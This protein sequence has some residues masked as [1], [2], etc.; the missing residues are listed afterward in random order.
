MPRIDYHL[1]RAYVSPAT[2]GLLQ[3]HIPTIQQGVPLKPKLANGKPLKL[4]KHQRKVLK[5]LYQPVVPT[6]GVRGRIL[7][8][9]MGAGKT[10]ISLVYALS[11]IRRGPNNLPTLIVCS[12]TLLDMWKTEGFDKFLMPDS[13]RVLYLHSAF[14]PKA[15]MDALTRQELCTY[16]VVV[17]TYDVLVCAD[18]DTT[19]SSDV[20][21]MGR[22]GVWGE[23]PDRVRY[24]KKRTRAQAD[25]AT[26]RGPGALF[27]TPWPLVV[28]DEPQRFANFKTKTF[29]AMMSVFGEEY[30]L[31][32]GTP[33]RN[34]ITDIW[35]LYR[36]M[37]YDTIKIPTKTRARRG[38]TLDLM[39]ARDVHGRCLR[40]LLIRVTLADL[41]PLPPLTHRVWETT[42]T[43]AA[44]DV[45]T[46]FT[47]RALELLEQSFQRKLRCP[48]VKT[49][50]GVALAAFTKL[51][52]I[53][54]A[55]HLVLPESK[56]KPQQKGAATSSLDPEN[57]LDAST[58]EWCQDRN[59]P[60][61]FGAA[62]VVQLLDLLSIIPATEKVLV[63]CCF[64]STIDLMRAALEAEGIVSSMLDGDVPAHKRR[65]VTTQFA[66]GDTRVLF[67]TYPVAAEGLNLVCA[68][69]VVLAEAWW[70]NAVMKQAVYRAWRYGQAKPVEVYQLATKGTIEPLILKLAGYKKCIGDAVL[71]DIT[72]DELKAI[73]RTKLNFDTI[74]NIVRDAAAQANS[75]GSGGGGGGGGGPA[76]RRASTSESQYAKRATQ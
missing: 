25:D 16:D 62:K 37:G 48:W 2:L 70:N 11:T 28:V 23:S 39:D 72:A 42:M 30:L 55:P 5:Q 34:H 52:Q 15:E 75:G 35:S 56:R 76:K 9:V 21:V 20:K 53:S 27:K 68:N 59:G 58:L 61:G 6:F 67:L 46:A 36:V 18:K 63:F 13:V 54:V 41:P 31:L 44:L 12:R 69:H 29:L 50:F 49:D 71:G 38:W 64:T 8:A 74:R 45:H 14:T 32:S 26:V 33:V 43:G 57:V 3:S 40:D 60:A 4:A 73:P 66:T 47:Q 65:G 22:V 17:T 1:R 19:A 7:A 24:I 10:L 51:R